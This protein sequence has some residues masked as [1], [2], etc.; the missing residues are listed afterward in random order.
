MTII[1]CRY[2]FLMHLYAGE[3]TR[4]QR[5]NAKIND[6][7]ALHAINAELGVDARARI[8]CPVHFHGTVGVED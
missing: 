4:R 5:R 2:S 7:Q 3:R 8:V 6:A 1:V